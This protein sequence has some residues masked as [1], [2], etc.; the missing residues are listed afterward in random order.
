MSRFNTWY[1]ILNGTYNSRNE[2]VQS[3]D[4]VSRW[5][6]ATRSVVF[7]MTANSVILGTLLSVLAGGFT[8]S[9]IPY[10]LL[11]LLGLMLAH[12]TSNLFNDYW[13]AKHG[14][15][16]TVGYF[17]PAYLP[18]P[19]ISGMM[20]SRGLF[21]LGLIHLAAVVSIAFY[22]ALIRGPTVLLF[23]GLRSEERRVGKEC[24]L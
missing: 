10:F 20:S 2:P 18:H 17:R 15:D 12:A 22:F 13:D 1:T 7:V 11:I 3:L 9:L 6:I 16:T 14:I 4:P 23:A 19:I 8:P 5:L 24:R 21:S